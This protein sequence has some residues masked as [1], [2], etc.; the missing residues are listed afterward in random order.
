MRRLAPIRRPPPL[1]YQLRPPMLR[2][3]R[4]QRQAEPAARTVRALPHEQHAAC[5]A[6]APR[7]VRAGRRLAAGGG[8]GGNAPAGMRDGPEL[9]RDGARALAVHRRSRRLGRRIAP[10]PLRDHP[11]TP[12][13]GRARAQRQAESATRAEYALPSHQHL[14]CAAPAPRAVRSWRRH[15]AGGGVD[16]DPPRPVWDC[17]ERLRGEACA[18]AL[19]RRHGRATFSAPRRGR[20]M[21]GVGRR[22]FPRICA[23]DP[24]PS[25][26]A[27]AGAAE[28]GLAARADTRGGLSA[29]RGRARP[30]AEDGMFGTAA[31]AAAQ[32]SVQPAHRRSLLRSLCWPP[33]GC[34]GG[35]LPC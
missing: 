25:N 3:A 27:A 19:R 17:P 23:A 24:P 12:V 5:A 13:P 26:G 14:A 28:S 34:A 6:L 32:P 16:G 4:A 8:I 10:V 9:W 2:R 31:A 7:S 22:P 29:Q 21:Y 1:G 18:P 30:G 33:A 20:R 35:G 11:R 15:A